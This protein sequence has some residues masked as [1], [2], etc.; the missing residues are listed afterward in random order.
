MLDFTALDFET[1]NAYPNSACSLAAV[2]FYNLQACH[3]A[4][5]C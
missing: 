1:A 5:T 4:K 3:I 2:M